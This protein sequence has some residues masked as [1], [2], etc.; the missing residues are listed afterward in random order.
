[1]TFS[2]RKLG[3][4]ISEK[5]TVRYFLWRIEDLIRT[6][7]FRVYTFLLKWNCIPKWQ[8]REYIFIP[9]IFFYWYCFIPDIILLLLYSW[10]NFIIDII[11]FLT[12]FYYWYFIL[13]M[14]LFYY[15]FYFIIDINLLMVLLYYLFLKLISKTSRVGT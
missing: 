2:A 10:Y 1:M 4:G 14:V 15:W 3:V 7:S 11:L 9:D 13:L 12:L 6:V 5:K 8:R